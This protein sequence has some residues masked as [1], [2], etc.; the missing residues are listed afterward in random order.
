VKTDELLAK[1]APLGGSEKTPTIL[2]HCREVFA[3]AEAI[4]SALEAS[5]VS[6]LGIDVAALRAELRPLVL[7]AALLHDL[8]K[9]N[10][11]FQAM[12][13][14]KRGAGPRQPVRHEILAG[15]LL[16]DPVY[17]GRWFGELRSEEDL[18]PI[19]WAVAGHHLKMGDP[20]RGASLFDTGSGTSKVTVHLSARDVKQLLQGVAETLGAAIPV[21]ELK[22]APFDTADEEEGGLEQSIARYAERSCRAWN[23]LRRKPE[24]VRRT[25][26]LKALLI[27][28]DVAGSA[29]AANEEQPAVWVTK[30]LSQR[31]RPD[32]LD[33]VIVQGTKKNGPLPFQLA[34]G[35][36]DSAATIVVAGCGNGKT[37]AAYLWA[38]R[39][40]TGRK[41]WFTYPTTGTASAG[42]QGYLFDHPDLLTAL[43]HGRAEVDLRAMQGTSEDDQIDESLRLESLRAWDRQAIVCTV[44]TVLGLLQNQRRP[45]F[46]F[47]AIA[48]GAFVFDELHSYDGRLFGA[49]L[50][51]LRLFPGVPTLLM[52]ASIPPGRMAALRKEL[53]GRAG[54]VIRGD[55]AMEQYRRYRLESRA[56]AEACRKDVADALRAGK[57]VLW[58]CNTVGDAVKTA[59]EAREWVEATEAKIIIYH[60]RFRY[61]DRVQRQNEVVAEFAYH[62]EGERKGQRVKPGPCL[63]VATQ[64]CEMSLD[65]SADLMLTAECPL[66]ALVQRLGRLNRYASADEPWTCLVYPFQGDPYNEKPEL[67]QTRGDFRASMAATREAVKALDGQP[68]SQQDFADRLKK[69]TEAEKVEDYSAWLD[70]GWVTE[71]AQ[72]RDG[73]G[74]ITLIREEDL[75]EIMEELGPE[76]ARP[77]KWTSRSLVP[78][79]IP[80]LYRCGFQPV[81]RVGGY[82]VTAEGTVAYSVEEGATWQTNKN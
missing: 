66:P 43:M 29:S 41:L 5:L 39:H 69:M 12:L 19:I 10:S 53:G 17:L 35:Q 79:T 22:D 3:A 81:R 46:S 36:S 34:V 49:L 74:S 55:P 65:I 23:Q 61:R 40:A 59:R 32:T 21:P 37:T 50:R 63:V 80:M 18:W 58:V 68:C 52:S 33:S 51:F 15:W 8:A 60:S 47:P 38:Q 45:L 25:A 72:L 57:K 14:A 9:A 30:A 24:V 6:A 2:Q 77:S 26:L 64:V 20:A 48:A 73:N 67:I 78:W 71:P 62:T 54:D 4:W 7:A 75:A 42:Y 28:A 1:S 70:D 16:T 82:P 27:S 31:L 44:D 11:A 13:R 56:S 76:H